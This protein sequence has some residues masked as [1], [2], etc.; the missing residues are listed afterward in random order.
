MAKSKKK[1]RNVLNER[2]R[3][4]KWETMWGKDYGYQGTM[5]VLRNGR[6]KYS[7]QKVNN[8]EITEI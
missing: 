8:S 1:E 4:S 6:F 2:G 3:R 5:A 7:N